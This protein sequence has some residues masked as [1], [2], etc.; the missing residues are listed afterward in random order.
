MMMMMMMIMRHITDDIPMTIGMHAITRVS[1]AAVSHVVHPRFEAPATMN[2]VTDSDF[3]ALRKD[4]IV[5][6]ARTAD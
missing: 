1:T 3:F 5:S 4:V 2:C 6:M